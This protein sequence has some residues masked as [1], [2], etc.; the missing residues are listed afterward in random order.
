MRAQKYYITANR[1]HDNFGNDVILLH[2]HWSIIISN[3][4]DVYK[5]PGGSLHTYNTSQLSR[6]HTAGDVI[7]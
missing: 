5:Q 3:V 4:V 6:R 7:M 1:S 2:A